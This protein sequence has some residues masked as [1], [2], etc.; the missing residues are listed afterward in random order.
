MSNTWSLRVADQFEKP[1]RD[2]LK[3]KEIRLETAGNEQVIAEMQQYV[4]GDRL[5]LLFQ[6]GAVTVP[7]D[8]TSKTI[9]T[10]LGELD[11]KTIMDLAGKYG[12]SI[13]DV[14]GFLSTRYKKEKVTKKTRAHIASFDVA[15]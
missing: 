13:D 15:V 8:I 2:E 3:T 14:I 5:N 9:T 6:N 12:L 1:V 11:E 10:T 7:T 4:R